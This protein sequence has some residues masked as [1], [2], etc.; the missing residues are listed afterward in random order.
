MNSLRFV[1]LGGC[2]LGLPA[3]QAISLFDTAPRVGLPES[4]PV[5]WTLSLGVGYD[6]NVNTINRS[7]KYHK[8]SWFVD[9]ALGS[10][11]SD[12]DSMT[13]LAYQARLGGSLYTQNEGRSRKDNAL[14][15][16]ELAVDLTHRFDS[17]LTYTTRNSISY[18]DETNYSLALSAVDLDGTVFTCV[19]SHSLAKAWD[20]RWSSTTTFRYNGVFY[21]DM[22]RP[23]YD[24]RQYFNLSQAVSFRENTRTSYIGT[25]RGQIVERE[26]GNDN[27]SLYLTG[28]VDYSLSPVSSCNVTLGAQLKV[29]SGSDNMWTPTVNMG[30]N[31]TVAGRMNINAYVAYSNES[32][33]TYYYHSNYA[34][35]MCWRLGVRVTQPITHVLSLHYGI[36]AVS[37]RYG[38]S[39][40]ETAPAY[41]DKTYRLDAGLTLRHTSN[42]SSHVSYS[43][44][45]AHRP[46]SGWNYVR[47]IWK[48]SLKYTF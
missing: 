17:T 42:I 40:T 13:S 12:Q 35:N 16:S 14:D 4:Y 20:P 29:Q 26:W 18:R 7:S 11:Y 3:V 1:V 23:S 39:G 22:E 34:S 6:D 30:Y 27:K 38:D 47:S 8:G 15:N 44:T 41:T 43:F 10:S 45:D 9:Y 19:S 2:C 25:V 37:S 24:N 5:R 36:S 21:S 32:V 28:G 48:Y 31:R 46:R 33:G